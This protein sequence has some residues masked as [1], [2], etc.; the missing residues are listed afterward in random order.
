[1]RPQRH[2]FD[3]P[4]EVAYLNCAYMSPSPRAVTEAG[5]AAAAGKAHPWTVRPSAFFDAPER[6]RGTFAALVGGDAD[7]VALVPSVSYALAAAGRN[8]AVEPGQR[9]L[10]LAE[11]FPSNVYPW[12]RLAAET[13]AEVAT[14]PRRPDDD[15]T[16]GL[17]CAI[18]ER[19]A[20]VAVPHCH[21]TDGTLVDLVAVRTA[22]DAVGAAV[23][24]DATQSLGALPLDVGAVRPDLLVAAGYKWL[25]GPYSLGYAWFAPHLRDGVPLEEGW[26]A[27]AGSDDFAGLVDY[28]DDY[29]P[30]ARRF[31]VGEVANFML[32]PMAQAALDQ[33]AAWG[34]AD[35]A[36]SLRPVTD[37]IVDRVAGFGV[38]AP[39]PERR[40]GHLVGLRLPAAADPSSLAAALAR[41]DV[42]VSVRGRSVRISPHLWTTAA[43]VERFLAALEA[44]LHGAPAAGQ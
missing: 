15:W 30:G 40:A 18:D 32:V 8:L 16:A 3:I 35:I 14:V 31:D 29:Q 25:L 23:V 1:M 37:G 17:L 5:R 12:R 6:L 44:A 42:H 33:I 2:L 22:C 7:G 9:L 38:T 39:P 19:T 27:R 43:D 36:A 4:D 26:C 10:V 34:V 11:Q 13:G 24:V 41:R 21:W 20:V 28:R